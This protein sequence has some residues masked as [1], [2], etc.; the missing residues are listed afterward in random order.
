[1][2]TKH[3]A[4]DLQKVLKLKYWYKDG[5]I[6]PLHGKRKG[7]TNGKYWIISVE[8]YPY[9][10]HRLVWV[11]FHGR[12]PI[13]V[14]DHI[15]QDPMD[16]RI[17]NLREVTQQQNLLNRGGWRER[18]HHQLPD[19]IYKDHGV[20]RVY[21]RRDGKYI[22]KGFKLQEEAI[23]FRDTWMKENFPTWTPRK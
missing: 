22:S 8:G 23:L 1:M 5:K 15:N 3:T 13:E 2:Y 10:E 12:W 9:L 16:N 7:S 17:E 11:W 18:P 20:F 21:I 4:A 6:L 14:L 19:M